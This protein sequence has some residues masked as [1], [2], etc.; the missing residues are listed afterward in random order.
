MPQVECAIC[1]KSDSTS[2]LKYCSK[3]NL[4]V[5]YSCAGG[6]AWSSAK[7]PVCAKKLG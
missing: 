7:C 5:H 4:W 6:G 1:K 3:D 2:N